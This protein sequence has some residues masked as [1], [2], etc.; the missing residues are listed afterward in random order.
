MFGSSKKK[1]VRLTEKQIKDLTRN[2]SGKEL[3]QFN[4]SQKELARKQ[5]RA[6]DDAFWDGLLWGSIFFDD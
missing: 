3:R 4:K 1:D 5:R 2:M 6:E